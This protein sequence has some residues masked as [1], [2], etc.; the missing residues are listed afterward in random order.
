[1]VPKFH[2]VWLKSFWHSNNL[3]TS[4]TL[5]RSKNCHLF[6]RSF[7]FFLLFVTRWKDPSKFSEHKAFLQCAC[8]RGAECVWNCWHSVKFFKLFQSLSLKLHFVAVCSKKVTGKHINRGLSIHVTS[9]VLSI[10]LPLGSARPWQ[11]VWMSSKRTS[12]CGGQMWNWPRSFLR[13]Y[14]CIS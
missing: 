12:G 6:L 10:L 7:K 13:K 9:L 8:F 2:S 3:A 5:H 4:D 11:R 1:M 14:I